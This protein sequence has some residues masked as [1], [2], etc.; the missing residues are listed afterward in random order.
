MP[1]SF[2]FFISGGLIMY[3][4]MNQNLII[5]NHYGDQG[6]V[7]IGHDNGFDRLAERTLKS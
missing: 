1:A 5:E 4:I 2:F 6:I 7:N 3:S